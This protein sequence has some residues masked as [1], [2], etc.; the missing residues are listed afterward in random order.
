MAPREKLCLKELHQRR[1]RTFS[2]AQEGPGRPRENF[3]QVT[4]GGGGVQGGGMG[5]GAGNRLR[6]GGVPP[7]PQHSGRDSAP[8]AFP[9]PN[10][11][12]TPLPTARNHPPTAF[13][14]PV[15]ALQPLWDCP[16]RSPPLQAKPWGGGG[17][18]LGPLPPLKNQVLSW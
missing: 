12:P 16:N 2:W 15:T 10:T 13:T 7:P 11:S 5:G 1:W 3:P 14:S 18:C 4:E 6:G 9:Y 8:K 17:G